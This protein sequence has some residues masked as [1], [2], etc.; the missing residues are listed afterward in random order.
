MADNLTD[1]LGQI[2]KT[3]RKSK[4]LSL[5]KL[6]KM[7]LKSRGTLYKYEN[8]YSS[9]DV[10]TLE[11]IANSLD[12][13]ADYLIREAMALVT[14][15]QTPE[16]AAN[17]PIVEYCLYFYDG[18][19]H[20]LRRSLIRTEQGDSA[21]MSA[22]LFYM[23]DDWNHPERCQVFYEGVLHQK[24]PC[25]SYYFT[26]T[27]NSMEKM[28][29]IA[30]EP[31]T[32]NGIMGGLLTGVSMATMEPICFKALHSDHKLVEDESLT[33]ALIIGKENLSLLKKY[34][35]LTIAEEEGVFFRAG[36]GTK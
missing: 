30:R 32:K 8:G 6:S 36:D 2:L 7:L 12:M 19:V 11:Q 18:R 31:F 21:E 25:A 33:D 22:Y 29:F 10:D 5:E 15:H 3:Y 24:L 4:G 26:N 16:E 1:A 13:K 17:R 28:S 23:L 14:A 27:I 35:G 9:M 20:E 34:N